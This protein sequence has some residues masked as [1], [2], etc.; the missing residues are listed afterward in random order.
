MKDLI[1]HG[2][3]SL[4]EKKPA[5]WQGMAARMV[6]A[7]A[8]G[9]AGMVRNLGEINFFGEDWQSEALQQLARIY[10]L[11]E[12]YRQLDRLSP[13]LQS[14]IR[15]LIGWAQNQEELKASPGISDDWLVLARQTETE[16]D[17]TIQRNWLYGANTQ[18]FA[19]IINFAHR[20]QAIDI[21]LAPGTTIEADLVYFPS[22]TPLRALLKARRKTTAIF[23]VE[24]LSDWQAVEE[25]YAQRLATNP[26]IDRTPLLMDGI[27]P[28]LLNNHWLLKDQN[29]QYGLID[30]QFTQHWKMMAYS[31]GYPL[32]MFLIRENSHFLPLGIWHNQQY[33]L[34]Y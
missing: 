25:R 1:R 22:S 3:L 23:P 15:L 26:W 13:A 18:Q 34:L 32:S 6:D 28:F 24:G 7:Q 19:L 4:P 20:T 21:T 29:G 16:Q 31:G 27:T 33:I 10:L 30:P 5:F 11:I 2:L 17:I 14:D 12:G 8:P 9:L